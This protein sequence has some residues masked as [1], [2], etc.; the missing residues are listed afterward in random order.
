MNGEMNLPTLLQNMR[1]ELQK[2]EYVF[3]SIDPAVA[4]GLRLSPI[5]QFH[6]DE[7]LTLI[8]AKDEAEANQ[9]E[10]TYRCRKI[11]LKVHSSLQAIGFLAVVTEKLAQQGISVNAISAYFHDHLFVPS[12]KAEDAISGLNDLVRQSHLQ[13]PRV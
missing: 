11:T 12:D 2:D 3:C 1:P 6:E 8:L 4:S 10:F 13:S 7:G 9:L 5:G